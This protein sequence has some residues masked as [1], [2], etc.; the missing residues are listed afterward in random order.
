MKKNTDLYVFCFEENKGYFF[1]PKVSVFIKI[2]VFFSLKIRAKGSFFKSEN[3]YKYVLPFLDKCSNWVFPALLG[4]TVE[5]KLAKLRRLKREKNQVY[6]RPY[7]IETM[8][9]ALNL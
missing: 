6:Q 3:T 8:H 5:S 4:V 1:T 2:G 9:S 7:I